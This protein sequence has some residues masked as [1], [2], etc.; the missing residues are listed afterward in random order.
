MSGLSGL[1]RR[2]VLVAGLGILSFT[3]AQ[4]A[5]SGPDAEAFTQNLINQGVAILRETGDPAR[6][7]KFRA[8][9]FQYADVERTAIFT[10][11]NYK[12]SASEAEIADFVTAFREFATATYESRLAQYKN[13]SLKVTGSVDNRPGDV[14]VNTVVVDRSAREPLRI[15]FRLLGGSS[16]YKFVDVQVEGIWL[17][18]EQKEQFGSFL[19]QNNGRLPRLTTD[20]NARTQR[21]LNGM[22]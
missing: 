13:Q 5:A 11:G 16:A 2:S 20:L 10:L 19:G 22:R 1:V 4:P 14:T 9:I 3:S 21:I 6:R 15:A 8:F 7:T 17:S 12:R 18:I